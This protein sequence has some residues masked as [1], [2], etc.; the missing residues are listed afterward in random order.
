MSLCLY[1]G[2]NLV[3]MDR[4][5]LL[6]LLQFANPEI[7]YDYPHPEDATQSVIA[8]AELG[9]MCRVPL[10]TNFVC[11]V[12]L[13]GAGYTHAKRQRLIAV[14]AGSNVV[15]FGRPTLG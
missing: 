4:Q 10:A 8:Y 9:L 15:P 12:I 13:T 5:R 14:Q 3:G 2:Y 1:E 6:D 11:E 7:S